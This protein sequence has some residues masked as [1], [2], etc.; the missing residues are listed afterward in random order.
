MSMKPNVQERTA[1]AGYVY[2]TDSLLR[3]IKAAFGQGYF[4][5]ANGKVAT[6][7]ELAAFLY[8]IN[9]LTARKDMQDET[10]V[11]KYFEESQ[12]LL[13]DLPSNPTFGFDWEVH[14]AYRWALQPDTVNSILNSLRLSS[15]NS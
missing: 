9:F 7:R 4:K 1:K 15:D 6:E 8:K 3:K 10:I 5:F 12:Y 11:R 13:P 2:N 14:P